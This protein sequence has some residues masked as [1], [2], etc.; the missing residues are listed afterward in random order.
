MFSA[1]F[2]GEDWE[3]F[4]V[5]S[6]ASYRVVVFA[7]NSV[8]WQ[9]DVKDSPPQFVGSV[10]TPTPTATPAP[11]YEPQLSD[12]I[13]GLGDTYVPGSWTADWLLGKYD[14]VVFVYL[15]DVAFGNESL[16]SISFIGYSG[17]HWGDHDDIAR[18]RYMTIKAA[19]GGAPSWM[20]VFYSPTSGSERVLSCLLVN[21]AAKS[22]INPMFW[23]ILPDEEDCPVHWAEYQLS[24]V[25]YA[26]GFVEYLGTRFFLD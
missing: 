26:A 8:S 10:P 5:P 14:D 13:I 12:Y 17:A 9:V 11:L 15:L 1:P 20:Q 7:P 4:R 24:G 18:D 19:A 23:D 21:I 16:S 3:L 6:L 2:S 22:L 25:S